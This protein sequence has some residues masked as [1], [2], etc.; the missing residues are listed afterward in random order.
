MKTLSKNGR[1]ASETALRRYDA[2]RFL[3]EAV[4][5]GL[6]LKTALLAASERTWGGRI[7]KVPTLERW[8]YQ[9]RHNGFEQLQNRRRSDRGQGRRL[10]PEAVEAL[11]EMRRAQ[12]DLYVATLLRQLERQ[13]TIPEGSVSLTTIYRTLRANGLDKASMKAAGAH[14]PTKAFEVSWSNQLWM[15]D[16]M[17]GPSL[18]IKAGGRPIRTHLLALIDDCSR[19]CPHG[20]YYQGE[21]IECFLD[22]FKHA[23]RSR[24]IPEK[25][26]TDNGALF[27]SEHLRSVCANF[28]IRLI[29]AK[30]YHAWSKGKIERFFLTVQSDFEQSLV[31]EPVK[32]LAEL[33]MRFWQWLERDY[34]QRVHRALDGKSPRE[35]FLA[36]SEGLRS[37]P[38]GM[39]VDGLFL[40]RTN[41]RVRRDATISLNGR[42]FE[43]PVSLRG[44]KVDVHFDPF[45][46]ERMELYVE[47]KKVGDATPLD[48]EINSRTYRLE[49]DERDK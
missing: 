10:S 28:G 8:Y 9:Y 18:P 41:R 7:Y 24:G 17:W 38:V 16:G 26:Y 22:L 40:K 14:G 3:E 44:R 48:K 39:D 36:R 13:G 4:R 34:H 21:K 37:I 1:W 33:N 23:L 11:L 27:R 19:L 31:F 45:T 35:R 46:Y 49:N 30:P 5:S 20:Q 42:M 25:L 29:H 47:E 32:D 12:P 2:V 43:V 6:S 15:T